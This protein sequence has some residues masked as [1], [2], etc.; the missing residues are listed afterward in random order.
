MA[1]NSNAI[2]ELSGIV[3]LE[4]SKNTPLKENESGT[5]SFNAINNNMSVMQIKDNCDQKLLVKHDRKSLE[6]PIENN[7][8]PK[9]NSHPIRKSSSIEKIINRFKKVRAN[10]C[11]SQFESKTIKEETVAVKVMNMD[12][13]N[14]KLLPDLLE[15]SHSTDMVAELPDWTLFNSPDEKKKTRESLGTA[16]GVNKIGIQVV[17]ALGVGDRRQLRK[18]KSFTYKLLK[19]GLAK[20][21]LPTSTSGLAPP[22]H[23]SMGLPPKLTFCIASRAVS[24]I[25]ANRRTQATGGGRRSDYGRN[26]R[27]KTFASRPGVSPWQGGGPGTGLPNLLPLAGT[28]ATLALANN[29]ITNLLQSRQNPVPSLLDIP[30]RRDFGPELGRFDRGYGP[31]RMGNQGTFRRTGTYSRTGE[32]I[33]SNRK[34]FKP[35]EGQRNRQSSPKTDADSIKAKPI[36]SESTE[37]SKETPK[38]ETTS[39]V[40]KETPKTRYD[41]IDSQYLRCHICNKSMWDGRSFENHLSGRAH[42]IMMQKTAES[43]ALTADTMRQEFKIREMK[44]TRKTGQQTPRDFY[45]AMCDMYAADGSTHRTT[46][47]HR[48]LKKYL[49]PGCTSCHKEMPTRIELDEHRLTPE[50]LR[51]V[52]DKQEVLTKLKPEVMVISTLSMEQSYVR[53]DRLRKRRYS[54]ADESKDKPEE[55]KD[56][57]VKEE[58]DGEGAKGS[59]EG[60][61]EMADKSE[62]NIKKEAEEPKKENTESENLVLDYKEGDDLSN[63]KSEMIPNYNTERAVGRSFLSPFKCVQCHL[64]HKLLDGEETADVHLR[65]W[66]HHQLFVRMLKEKAGLEGQQEANKRSSPDEREDDGNWKRRKT[67]PDHDRDNEQDDAEHDADAGDGDQANGNAVE[68]IKEEPSTT[69]TNA[70]EETL[71]TTTEMKEESDWEKTV[72]EIL[73]AEQ[74]VKDVKEDTPIVKEKSPEIKPAPV[75]SVRGRG[76]TPRGRG[77]GRRRY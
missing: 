76:G 54:H 21:M 4:S 25:M 29:L 31:N 39:E 46:V 61:V 49:H 72:D 24:H 28:E 37:E 60:D 26:D 69:E 62:G 15:Q 52:Q 11:E 17:A 51:N 73:E 43:Y 75:E 56:P 22:L 64:C 58:K 20:L 57:K 68:Q 13:K 1:E 70:A 45:C 40:K 12:L 63:F 47:G 55:G 2:L 35:N 5:P 14:K 9:L 65:T 27:G 48:K 7:V 32:R 16:L 30:I 42:A 74:D 34:P 36:K 10:V 8:T 50:H 53:D 6:S 77:R 33:N 44:R 18:Q 41:D 23:S 71:D 66:R 3:A 67:T 59:T 19:R 38:S